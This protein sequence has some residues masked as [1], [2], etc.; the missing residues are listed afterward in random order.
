MAA[1]VPPEINAIREHLIFHFQQPKEVI[2]LSG[3]PSPNSALKQL[4][5]ACFNPGGTDAPSILPPGDGNWQ[6][7]GL[8]KV[9]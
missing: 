1:A 9:K 2:R 5:L 3:N 4:Q 7:P 6:P 8:V